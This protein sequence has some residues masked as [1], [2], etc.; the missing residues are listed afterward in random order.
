MRSSKMGLII[1]LAPSVKDLNA[2]PSFV[3]I[4][5]E[6]EAPIKTM[7]VRIAVA[8]Q[9]DC[10]YALVHRHN[11][12]L[13]QMEYLSQFHT[14][15]ILRCGF[16]QG[17][18]RAFLA[19]TSFANRPAS[20]IRCAQ[21]RKNVKQGI[22]LGN[23]ATCFVQKWFKRISCAVMFSAVT[24]ALV[25]AMLSVCL[26]LTGVSTG[27]AAPQRNALLCQKK[28]SFFLRYFSE[29]KSQVNAED[30]SF[31]LESLQKD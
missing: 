1:K 24:P 18:W 2:S 13:Y 8:L 30:S 26:S 27:V 4:F 3:Q 5:R 15:P 14:W 29:Y 16:K 7:M 21:R 10:G 17:S 25:A 9:T 12:C 20:L 6:Q 22:R 28:A 19:T 23:P 11:W 31:I